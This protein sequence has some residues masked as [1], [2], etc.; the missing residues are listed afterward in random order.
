MRTKLPEILTKILGSQIAADIEPLLAQ[1]FTFNW[2][3][4]TKKFSFKF[5]EQQ[6]LA[7]KSVKLKKGGF[8][9]NLLRKFVS[10]ITKNRV[11]SLPK[12]IH[13]TV[14]FETASVEFKK[15]TTFTIRT[16]L[17]LSKKLGLQM[18]SFAKDKMID[19]VFRCFGTQEIVV[20][21]ATESDLESA[22][23]AIL[24]N[25]PMTVRNRE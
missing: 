3:G 23:I 22:R 15:G 13:G 21:T 20:D 11:I 25:A 5:L 9:Q 8:F 7:I 2:D 14:N 10:W 12:E 24:E 4:E 19:V 18:F 1:S 6:T 16:A 17:G